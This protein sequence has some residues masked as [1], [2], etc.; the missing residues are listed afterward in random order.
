MDSFINEASHVQTD[1]CNF[2]PD[3]RVEKISKIETQAEATSLPPRDAISTSIS[4]W[5]KKWYR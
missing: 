1:R 2:F 5:K 4:F 3:A